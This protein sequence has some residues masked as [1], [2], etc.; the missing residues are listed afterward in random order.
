[1]LMKIILHLSVFCKNADIYRRCL[2]RSIPDFKGRFRFKS[3]LSTIF[4]LSSGQGKCGVSVI[5]VSGTQTNEAV[6]KLC[7]VDTLP[8]PREAVLKRLYNPIT[9]EQLDRGLVLWFPG[10]N[11]F[12]G[13]DCCE[14]HVHGGP[15]VVA[16]VEHALRH[17]PGLRHAEAGE[18]TKRAFWND[19]LDLTEVEGLA[20]LIHAET[21][22][23]RKQA[24]RQM[25]GDLS[26][27]YTRWRKTIIKNMAYVEAYIDF[28]EDD[29]IEDGVLDTVFADIVELRREIQSHL[30]DNRQGERLRSGVHV[31]IV[32]LPNVGK[33]SLLNAICQR[34]AAIVS[35]IAGTTRDVVET[36]LNIGGY[37]VLLSDTAGLRETDNVIEKEGV[38]RALARA[39]QADFKIV[40]LEASDIKQHQA[41]TGF[42]ISEF[43]SSH[44]VELGLTFSTTNYNSEGKQM[45]TMND[46]QTQQ[47]IA[48]QK[49]RSQSQ[50]HEQFSNLMI[51]LNKIDLSDCDHSELFTELDVPFPVCEVSCE[52]GQG[53]DA[54]MQVLTKKM[55][56]LCGNPLA[57]NPCLTHS[58]H[59]HHITL[60]SDALDQYMTLYDQDIVLGAQALRKASQQIGKITG[61]IS[62]EEILDVV[63]RDFCIGK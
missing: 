8:Q 24:V 46:L 59:R 57:G 17:V 47:R 50:S 13:E 12:T 61:K 39:E 18:F 7:R 40:V 53:M 23:Q 9:S 43:I 14:F 51:V 20:A 16:A 56:D 55:K 2:P 34:P 29:N 58:R 22:F 38:K 3:S 42:S 36:A 27:M 41:R 19:K 33:S 49:T 48:Y 11:S 32:G 4:A 21:E 15:A 45:E 54:F 63:F 6:K 5:R 28:S 62:S 10:P 26:R 25:E 30:S 44:L 37:P 35:P 1:M 31:A 60:C 52:T